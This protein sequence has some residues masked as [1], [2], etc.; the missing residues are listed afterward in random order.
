MKKAKPDVICLQELKSTDRNL[1]ISAVEE[2][3]YGAVWRGEK[4]WNGVPILAKDG[5]PVTRYPAIPRRDENSTTDLRGSSA[6]N[7]TH[8]PEIRCPVILAGDCSVALTPFDIYRPVCPKQRRAAG[9]RLRAF[10][11]A[12]GLAGL[13]R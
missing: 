1:P 9:T 8:A 6:C 2:A 3:G 5:E 4:T 10:C 7:A 11:Y 13:E 12:A